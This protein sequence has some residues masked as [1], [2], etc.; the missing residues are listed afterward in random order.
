MNEPILPF[1]EVSIV[2]KRL[3]TNIVKHNI[4]EGREHKVSIKAVEKWW[5]RGQDIRESNGRC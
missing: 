4:C 2:S 5:V 1:T 3:K